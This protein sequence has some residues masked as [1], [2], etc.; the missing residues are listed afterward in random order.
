MSM[1]ESEEKSH[2]RLPLSLPKA[3]DGAPN[4]LE[5]EDEEGVAIEQKSEE[6]SEDE[7]PKTDLLDALRSVFSRLSARQD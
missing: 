4:N 7:D 5:N 6:D 3:K 1:L 2:H